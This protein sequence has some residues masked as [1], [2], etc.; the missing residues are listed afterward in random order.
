M[1]PSRHRVAALL[2]LLAAPGA[3]I[4]TAAVADGIAGRWQLNDTLTREANPP[5][6]RS[7]ST[8][9]GFGAPTLVVGGIPVP[10]PGTGG[11]QPGIGGSSP[12]PA[13]LRTLELVIQPAGERI[14]LDYVGVATETLERGNV[15]GQKSRWDE[16]SLKTSYETTTREVSQV[17]EV[18]RDGRLQVEVKLNPNQ[19]R[20]QKHYRVFDRIAP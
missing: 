5:E 12:D 17:Y 20:T 11:A 10:I 4:A 9:G 14:T 7:N 18:D 8:F 1:T 13:V 2:L 3:P 15:Q 16:Q 6:K 19:G